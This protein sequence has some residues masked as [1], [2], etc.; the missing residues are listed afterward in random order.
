MNLE[1]LLAGLAA[2][3]HEGERWLILADWLEDQQDPRAELARL[4]W[5]Y[6]YEHDHPEFEPRRE[7]MC[8]LWASGLP[9]LVPTL[10]NALGM[11]FA[12]VPPGT[13]WMGSPTSDPQ[14]RDDELRHRETLT[15]PFFLGVRPVT[16]AEFELF[17]RAA[18]YRTRGE[19]Q[20]E[21]RTWRAPGFYQDPRH[22][23]V[24]VD[25]D[26]G[27]ALVKWLNANMPLS[28]LAYALPTEVQW[29]YA[30]RAGSATPYFWG[31]DRARLG[32]YAWFDANAG[33]MTQRVDTKLPNPWGLWHMPGMVWE[34]TASEY[35]RYDQPRAAQAEANALMV[36]RGGGWDHGA[37]TCRSSFRGTLS[38]YIR[39]PYCGLRLALQPAEA[40]A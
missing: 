19:Q 2:H 25:W 39:V 34:W 18:N 16:V 36:V 23:V 15:A 5:Q 28:G 9:L 3:P 30:C 10:T 32:D 7:R 20:N 21:P 8:A 24:S 12:L 13:F 14:R 31:H 35:R 4:R 40:R 1:E 38:T 29:E 33:K 17:V 26:D 6:H 37:H 22:P 27:Q 11:T